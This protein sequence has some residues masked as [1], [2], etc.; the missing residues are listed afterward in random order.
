MKPSAN[1]DLLR[2]VAVLLVF[3]SHLPSA[4]GMP[5]W[6]V[7]RADYLGI[8]G[9]TLFF[10]H[11]SLVLSMS[12]ARLEE[13]GQRVTASFYIRR[14]FRIY[15]LSMLTVLLVFALR[16]PPGFHT[17]FVYPDKLNFWSN[18]LLFQNLARQG[19]AIGPLWSLPYEVQMY[20]ALPFLYF[21]GKKLRRP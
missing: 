9:V 19:P 11:T 3:T 13:Q 5:D 7:W 16:I 15:P 12:L 2:S 14:A 21:A 4:L 1:L 20:F 10:I 18:F 17:P 8:Y 6:S